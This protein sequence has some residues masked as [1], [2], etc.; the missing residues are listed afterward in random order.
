MEKIKFLSEDDFFKIFSKCENCENCENCGEIKEIFKKRLDSIFIN[1]NFCSKRSAKNFFL[2][3]Q[4]FVN[5]IRITDGKFLVDENDKIIFQKKMDFSGQLASAS[6]T[7]EVT[8]KTIEKNCD[9]DKLNHQRIEIGKDIYIVVD[10]PKNVVCSR[11]SDSHKTIF[12]WLKEEI[13]FSTELK[14]TCDFDT[15][16]KLSDHRLDFPSLHCVGRLDSETTG[17]LILTTDGNFSHFVTNPENKIPKT[18]EATLRDFV[19]E[20][21]Q[22]IYIEKTKS[23]ILLPA[24]KKSPKEMSDSAI[25]EW[26]FES[27]KTQSNMCKITVTEG[28]FH[29]V[30]RI[31]TALGN[32]VK[33]LRRIKIG[34]FSL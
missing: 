10:K 18:Y 3:N 5:G 24:E 27:E 11:V 21:N 29:E 25:I 13:D 20:E 30:R 12:E 31:F 19:N 33:K 26:I 17:L 32:E 34:E 6:Y 14:M 23:G 9:F 7:L 15:S 16:T 2:K 8:K 28:K 22:K 4:V 1:Q